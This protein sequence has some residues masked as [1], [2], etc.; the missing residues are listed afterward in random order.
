MRI[1]ITGAS[2]LIGTALTASLLEDGHQVL[3]LVRHHARSRE[4]D[5]VVRVHWRPT[6]AYVDTDAL[7]GVDAVVNLAGA[8]V[9]PGRWTTGRR[10]LIRSSRVQSTRVLAQA[11]AGMDAPPSRLLSASGVNFY[12]DTGGR[13]ADEST[14]AGRGFLAE[15]TRDWERATAP[16]ERA[17]ISVAHL[18]TGVVLDAHGGLLGT[19]LPLF[20]LG[21]GGRLGSGRQYLS[22]I[23]VDDEV[24]AIRF[25]L[26]RPDV[27]GPVNLCAPEPVSN[28]AYTEALG[29]ALRRPVP[30][31][32][33][34]P[35]MHAVLGAFAQE[36]ALIDLRVRPAR[37]LSAGYSFR[38]SDID[39][40]L[41]DILAP[42]RGSGGA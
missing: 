13:V 37:L 8:P 18:R 10:R 31:A 11:L 41:S 23:S 25:L 14:P 22:W 42:A 16:A 1:A 30:A 20:R 4:P 27:T 36:T 17:G 7:A 28:A 24:G 34:A 26:E 29:R 21:L 6:R 40:A 12:G 2:G 9:G 35:V 39:S 38:H 32:V 19:V 3:H 33:P 15:V 5:G